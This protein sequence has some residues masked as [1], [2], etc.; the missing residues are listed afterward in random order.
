[1]PSNNQRNNEL[2]FTPTFG[3]LQLLVEMKHSSIG[4]GAYGGSDVYDKMN[5]HYQSKWADSCSNEAWIDLI[6]RQLRVDRPIEY[7][8]ENTG[9]GGHAYVITGFQSTSMNTT[10]NLVNWG[11]P[12][13]HLEYWSLQPLNPASSYPLSHSMLYGIS[14]NAAVTQ[15][16]LLENESTD[17]SG[18]QIHAASDDGISKTITSDNAVFE[19]G[20]PPGTYHFTI[21]DTGNYFFPY[22][23]DGTITQTGI[24]HISPNPIVLTLK[25]NVVV[26][27][28][29]VPTIQEGI[30]L[31]RNGGT[32]A[33]L[34][35]SYTVSGLNWKGKHIKLQGQSQS[36]VVLTNDPNTNLPAIQLSDD[37]NGIDNRDI[38]SQITFRNCDLTESTEPGHYR[39]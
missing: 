29:D 23:I 6:K 9:G 39:R 18:I 37:G 32:V 4:S 7:H 33:M 17:Y 31:V 38:I 20:L 28:T 12:W 16:I 30:D 8:G 19:F 22:Q 34:N 1:M 27:P 14:P 25:P 15:T 36:G 13:C 11:R 21:T 10:L 3:T 2:E 26:V 24:N 35:G 5:M